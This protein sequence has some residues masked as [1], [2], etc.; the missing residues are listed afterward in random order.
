M[1]YYIADC[2]FGHQGAIRFDHRPFDT[3]EEMERVMISNWNAVVSSRDTVY[4]L[5]D[6]CWGKADDWIRILRRLLPVRFLFL[7][8]RS[9]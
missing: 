1:N 8:I 3:V 5:G 2:H 4:I 6:F 9:K 7:Q